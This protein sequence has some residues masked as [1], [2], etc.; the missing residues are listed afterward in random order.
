[1]S[2]R[3]A[4]LAGIFTLGVCLVSWPG[5]MSYDSMYALRQARSGIETGGYPPMVS[6][7][8]A[9]C[10]RIIPG[11]GGMF[12]LQNAL[13]FLGVAALGRALGAGDFRILLAM[14]VVAFAPATLG[15]ML[16]V[17]KDVAFGGLMALGYAFTL[18]YLARPR[19]AAALSALAWLALASSFR[20]NGIAAAVPAIAAIAWT[21]SR[22]PSSPSSRKSKSAAPASLRQN[23]W[24]AASTFLVLTAATLGFVVLTVTWRLPDLERIS[25]PSGSGGTQVHDL[26]GISLCAERNLLPSEIYSGEMTPERLASLYRPEHSQLAFGPSPLLDD[27][28]VTA[29][30]LVIEAKAVEARSRHPFCYL[31]HRAQVFVYLMGANAGRVFYLTESGVFPGEDGTEL[32]PTKL[33]SR[34]LD[35]LLNHDASL[36]ARSIFFALLAAVSLALA[37]RSANRSRLSRA[38]LPMAG[39]LA[40]LTGSFFMLPAADARYNFWANLVFIVTFCCVL[41]MPAM[42][43]AFQRWMGRGGEAAE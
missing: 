23:R 14:L 34:A 38:L 12:V 21:M 33:T 7:V 39:A 19:L 40:Y 41:P 1:M 17:W 4:A 10:E 15:P 20:I 27:A 42:P 13:V 25:M 24:M 30:A 37:T 5:F 3:L 28:V 8:W 31:R 32:V 9:L 11:Q 35:Y 36:A 18:R 2:A 26:I 43:R 22:G 6:Y 16:V 29:N